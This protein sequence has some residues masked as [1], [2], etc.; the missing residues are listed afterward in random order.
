MSKKTAAI[1]RSTAVTPQAGSVLPQ[2]GSVPSTAKAAP[3]TP[4]QLTAS[5][6]RADLRQQSIEIAKLTA[7]MAEMAKLI[8]SVITAS[9]AAPTV[10]PTATLPTVKV[11]I[12]L[13]TAERQAE[14]SI[15]PFVSL[16]NGK[17]DGKGQIFLDRYTALEPFKDYQKLYTAV[18]VLAVQSKQAGYGGGANWWQILETVSGKL[19]TDAIPSHIAK[20]LE[21]DGYIRQVLTP[22]SV[23]YFLEGVTPE[24]GDLHG[25]AYKAR[26]AAKDGIDVAAQFDRLV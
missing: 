4:A 14:D 24:Q 13:T 17:F 10:A 3:T 21:V 26:K 20:Q 23:L 9:K 16:L 7:Q 8:G 6:D 18:A 12:T 22:R 15:T 1:L 5:N 2:A 11:P 19:S 25:K